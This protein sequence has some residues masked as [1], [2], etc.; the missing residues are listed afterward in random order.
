MT[1][2]NSSLFRLAA[3]MPLSIAAAFAQTPAPQNRPA[4]FITGTVSAPNG[5]P[6]PDVTV[7]LE[8][9]TRA[10]SVEGKTDDDGKFSFLA[11]KPGTYV[12]R[13]KPKGFPDAA[14]HPMDLSLG[15]TK[16]IDLVLQ[17]TKHYH[18][19]PPAPTSFTSPESGDSSIQGTVHDIAGAPIPD[20]I[21]TLRAKTRSQSVEA[22]TG[23][24]GTFSFPGLQAGTYVVRVRRTGFRGA[25]TEP[26]QL[27]P[28]QAKEIHF[29]LKVI[30]PD[31][32]DSPP[33]ELQP[34]SSAK[35]DS[36]QRRR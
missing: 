36:A 5:D 15:D 4:I 1:P 29:A 35:P 30:N 7:I 28:G 27:S 12:V 17:P 10:E 34:S 9:K 24:D 2:M 21:V 33:P 20:S 32:G 31:N 6:V 22:K 19:L 3:V 16:Q 25:F 18:P 23:K 14:T 11:L 13:A 8:E 26:M